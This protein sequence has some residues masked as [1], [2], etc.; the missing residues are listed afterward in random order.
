M[1]KDP[2]YKGRT[3]S[4]KKK[5]SAQISGD[6]LV[7]YEKIRETIKKVSKKEKVSD[8]EILETLIDC[9]L[10]HSKFKSHNSHKKTTV[11]D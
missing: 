1:S 9:T 2:F 10:S 5:F 3:Y 7:G 6:Y 8:S 11:S 4:E